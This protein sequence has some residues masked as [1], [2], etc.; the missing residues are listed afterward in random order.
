MSASTKT[1]DRVKHAN[2]AD[3]LAAFQQELPS[4]AKGKQ[5]AAG[6]YSYQYAGIDDIHPIAMPLLGK[7]GLSFTT[8]P[9]LMG[10]AFVLRYALMF[11]DG[12]GAV[13]GVYPLPDP[14]DTAPQKLGSAITY[15]R[16][17]AF[18]A[19]TGIA[20]GGDDDDAAAAN[21]KPAAGRKPRAQRPQQREEPPAP[22]VASPGWAGQILDA[23]TV[24]ELRAVYDAVEAKGELGR[25]FA[26]EDAAHMA[27]VVKHF[28]LSAPPADVKVSQLINAV[29]GAMEAAPAGP[30]HA[31]SNGDVQG[32]LDDDRPA[33]IDDWKVAPIPNG[34]ES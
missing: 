10:E 29:R 30:A 16:R 28:G 2:I 8:Q 14:V 19:V 23:N 1:E 31:D 20:P 7:H 24:D 11:E 34:D 25:G 32:G 4:I 3:A 21:D 9:T 26:S 15:A 33:A 12:E 6:Q 5:A 13:E 18:C 27:E 17:Y 22:V